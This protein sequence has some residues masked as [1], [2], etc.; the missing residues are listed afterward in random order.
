MKLEE[1]ALEI[2]NSLEGFEDMPAAIDGLYHHGETMKDHLT[3]TVEIIKDLCREFKISEEDKDMLS[4]AGW[5]HDIGKYPITR[6]GLQVTSLIIGED[7]WEYYEKTDYSRMIGKMEEHST[8]GSMMMST[9]HICRKKEIQRLIEI[10][11][12]HWYPKQPQPDLTNLF[13]III[14]TAD[15]LASRGK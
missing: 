4:A 11:M 5:L 15:Y 10:H 13:E 9:F 7:K 14:C 6:K 3:Q 12:S 8:L 2:L 1:R